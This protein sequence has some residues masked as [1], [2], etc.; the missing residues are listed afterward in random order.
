MSDSESSEYESESSE[1]EEEVVEHKKKKSSH[2]KKEKKEKKKSK[3]H[4]SS[5]EDEESEEEVSE[6]ESEEEEEIEYEDDDDEEEIDD[7]EEGEESIK[8]GALFGQFTVRSKNSDQLMSKVKCLYDEMTRRFE[9]NV[10]QYNKILREYKKF[11]R[12]APAPDMHRTDFVKALDSKMSIVIES[13]D[14][15][16]DQD[17]A[18]IENNKTILL[19]LKKLIE[20]PDRKESK[21]GDKK[22]KREEKGHKTHSHKDHKKKKHKSH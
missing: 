1:Q 3:K 21:S 17:S 19:F 20:N 7:D 4:E 22:R 15:S 10:D 9:G 13:L 8:N 16:K 5:S 11:I 2:S 6:E 12:K 14:D 18:I